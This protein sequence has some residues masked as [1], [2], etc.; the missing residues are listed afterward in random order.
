MIGSK[1]KQSLGNHKFLDPFRGTS[2][3]FSLGFSLDDVI[4][5]TRNFGDER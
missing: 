1:E 5:Q 4:F 2:K 3:G